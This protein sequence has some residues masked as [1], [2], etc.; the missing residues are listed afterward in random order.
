MQ[1]RVHYKYDKVYDYLLHWIKEQSFSNLTKIPSE[2]ML[3]QKFGVSRY[4]VRKATDRLKKEGYIKS[5]R[6]SGA[7]VN[8]ASVI[9]DE[10]LS[11]SDSRKV[12][13]VMQG[14]DRNAN[15]SLLRGL[16]SVFSGEDIGLQVFF[17]DNLF[18]NER[19]CLE[20]IQSQPFCGIIVDG[21]KANLINPNRDCYDRIA[22]KKI[23]VV[24]YNNYYHHLPYPR[25]IIN[26]K[27]AADSLMNLLIKNGHRNIAGIFV[28]DNYQ[29]IEKYNG[30]ISAILKS[31]IPFHDDFV[32]W[33]ISSEAHR[34]KFINEIV[35]F[36]KSVP[37]C[38]AIVCCNYMLLNYVVSAVNKLS[39]KIPKDYSVVCFDYSAQDYKQSG[40]SCSV[41]PGFKI[42]VEA[43]KEMLRCI[44]FGVSNNYTKMIDPEIY[45]GNSVS[46]I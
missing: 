37:Q 18:L 5:V 24:F 46:K 12:A 21:V 43:A 22:E 6:G 36:L 3:C 8:K 16:K 25:V 29:S 41:H 33:S 9:S 30:Y 14:Q 10:L 23:P 42:G 35:R 32:K 45:Y 7:F 17:T 26:D 11:A 2:N 40:I 20:Y 4:T 1:N 27:L 28:F 15:S 31:G 44:K 39:K 19:K 38:S 13:V 34:P